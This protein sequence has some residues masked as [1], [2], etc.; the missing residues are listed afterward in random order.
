[1]TS[2]CKVQTRVNENSQNEPSSTM[3]CCTRLTSAL[4]KASGRNGDR[5][6]KWVSLMMART[7][8]QG[9]G[10]R[11]DRGKDPRIDQWLGHPKVH[12]I[13]TDAS[14]TTEVLWLMYRAADVLSLDEKDEII[15]AVVS[16]NE[17]YTEARVW[18]TNF[19]LWQSVQAA[20][21]VSS[22]G[23]SRLSI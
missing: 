18:A 5:T 6:A 10:L 16:Q 23:Y 3:P 17:M 11:D 22:Y 21:P 12:I 2:S 7:K 15:T 20:V 19:H 9:D 8:K 14:W 4:P 13:Y 1:M